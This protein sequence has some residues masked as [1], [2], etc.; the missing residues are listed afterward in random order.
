MGS[1]IRTRG[2]TL[3]ELMVVL[4]VVAVILS[5]A[6]SVLPDRNASRLANE[7]ARLAK[8]L[9]TLQMEALLQRTQTGLVLEPGGYRAVL[10]NLQT[11]E[12]ESRESGI[13]G[14]RLLEEQGLAVELN[15]QEGDED[16]APS[17]EGYPSIVFDAVGV[18]DPYQLQ[19]ADL[20]IDDLYTTVSS[21]GLHKAQV[22]E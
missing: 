12:W 11:L 16:K 8:A 18:S 4:V 1:V 13:L 19:L 5:L 14:P 2:F 20:A 9:N 22:D 10:L 7:A 21:D 15:A 3:I 6:S 17:P